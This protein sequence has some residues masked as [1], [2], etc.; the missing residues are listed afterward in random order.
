MRILIL[1]DKT[2]R[3]GPFRRVLR[4]STPDADVRTCESP[5]A[6][7]AGESADF[8]LI[9]LHINT[10]GTDTGAFAL[11]FLDGLFGRAEGP[12]SLELE[13][14]YYSFGAAMSAAGTLP[15]ALIY[16]G[17]EISEEHKHRLR[18]YGQRVCTS[19]VEV[20]DSSVSA[21]LARRLSRALHAGRVSLEALRS[22]EEDYPLLP[23]LLV[24]CQGYLAA[25]ADAKGLQEGDFVSALEALT[26]RR[27]PEAVAALRRA[28]PGELKTAEGA[29]RLKRRVREAEWWSSVGGEVVPMLGA[30]LEARST[31]GANLGAL[32]ALLEE[33]GRGQPIEDLG[34]VARAYIAGRALLNVGGAARS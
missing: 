24:L 25:H 6:F 9:I 19:E 34:L 5:D 15:A 8:D 1:D 26:G 7:G 22:G 29:E 14:R 32:R 11:S 12:A 33:L 16:S 18:D 21:G 28:L 10:G 30:E 4:A 17:G 31:R 27:L 23:A 2:G 3:F 20:N 13:R